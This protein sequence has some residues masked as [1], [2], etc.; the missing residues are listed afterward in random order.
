MVR[1]QQEHDLTILMRALGPLT[2]PQLQIFFVLQSMISR[3]NPT[4]PALVDADI[5]EAAAAVATSFE[6]AA[7]GVLYEQTAISPSAE[8]LRRE[9]KTFLATLEGGK[10]VRFE[11]EVA[12]VLRGIERG[13][14]HEISE[15]GE[16]ALS[17][18]TLIARILHQRPPDRERAGSRIILP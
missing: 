1:R 15:I 8:A 12:I 18:L 4:G 13:A 9:L 5:A 3:F 2:E 14:R 10:G 7:R 16:G 6:T 17:Y 11:R